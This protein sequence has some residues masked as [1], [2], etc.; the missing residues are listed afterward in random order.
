MAVF[1]LGESFDSSRLAHT[2]FHLNR[3]RYVPIVVCQMLKK[4]SLPTSQT[5]H[6]GSHSALMDFCR[7]CSDQ[8]T[9]FRVLG[10]IS[11]GTKEV[12]NRP[13]QVNAPLYL[14]LPEGQLVYLFAGG[15]TLNTVTLLPFY[16]HQSFIWCEMTFQ[17]LMW[18][19]FYSNSSPDG[20]EVIKPLWVD[21]TTAKMNKWNASRNYVNV[22]ERGGIDWRNKLTANPCENTLKNCS[23]LVKY[24]T[25]PD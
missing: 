22:F 10:T 2:L 21:F 24:N 6:S 16:H 20:N 4:I 23:K 9:Y 14:L 1:P 25:M 7:V 17:L 12:W 8:A 13:F 3:S 5:T 11:N 19:Q 15:K 18:V